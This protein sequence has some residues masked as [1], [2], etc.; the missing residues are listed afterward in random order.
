M[1]NLIVE[2]KNEESNGGSEE[3]RVKNEESNSLGNCRRVW[4]PCHA[5]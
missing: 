4:H 3:R 1:K 5:H 2:V